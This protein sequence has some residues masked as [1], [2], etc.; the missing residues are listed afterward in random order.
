MEL[1]SLHPLQLLLGGGNRRLV[2]CS[3]A[4]CGPLLA[5]LAALLLLPLLFLLLLLL[6]LL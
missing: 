6:L 4:L 2:W 5:L 3:M 1:L